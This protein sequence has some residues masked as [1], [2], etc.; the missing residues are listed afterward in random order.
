LD[1]HV[2]PALQATGGDIELVDVEG[3]I[4]MVR[5]LGSC[6]GCPSTAMTILMDIERQLRE[7]VSGVEYL[8]VS[9]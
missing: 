3:G 9:P 5:L 1:R 6:R 7:L 8:E 4:V 2:R